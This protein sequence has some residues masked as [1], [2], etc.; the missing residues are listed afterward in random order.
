MKKGK[1]EIQNRWMFHPQNLQKQIDE[2]G[3]H[4]SMGGYLISVAAVMGGIIVCGAVF[5]LR[6]YMT[7]L[8]EIT[9]FLLLPGMIL[10]GYKNMYEHKRFLDVSDYMEQVLY[11]FQMEHKILTAL[12]D[13]QLLF[14]E[15]KM[16]GVLQEAVSYME[17]GEFQENLYR[18]ALEKIETEYPGRRV[19]A[20]HQFMQ[21]VE[22]N[23]GDCEGAICLLL[24]D[25]AV[26]VEN[27]V[28]LQE[29]KKA[30]RTRILIA[31]AITMILAGMFHSIYRTMPKEYSILNHTVTQAVT[32]L[33]LILNLLIFR[34]AGHELAG[35]WIGREE[36]EDE[37][38]IRRYRKV[39]E[40]Q[41]EHKQWNISMV[42]AVP[43][44]LAAIVCTWKDQL[45]GAA[46]GVLLTILLLNQQK[47]AYHI[48]YEKMVKEIHLRF[49]QWL[50]EL[51]L[52]L[53]GNNVQVAIEKTI[54]G[55]PLV[56]RQDLKK[57]VEQLK[58]QPDAIEPYLNFLNTFQLSFIQSTMKMLYAISESG[59]GDIQE[60]IQFM[61]RRNGKLLDK[62]EKLK[63]EATLAGISVVSYYP[64]ITIS[65]QMMANLAVFILAFLTK[66][67]IS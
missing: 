22:K 29:D 66:L 40:E 33:Y 35:S 43:A 7:V 49:P 61:V 60:Q 58:E 3:Y 36:M 1:T 39:V 37:V 16:H 24:E 62:S 42:C 44:L 14:P 31:L 46:G 55:A 59:S 30:A 67:G 13:T 15:G 32:T 11:A 53:Q 17:A 52:L 18:E 50:M 23:G 21:T 51:A 10:D 26:W 12:K 28:L 56:F 20:I 4:F 65:F 19:A 54:P 27:T 45:Y 57:L 64:Q 47:I 38:R 5:S 41:K 34:K 6:W 9:A 25:K 2:Y 48:S 8:V 63:N